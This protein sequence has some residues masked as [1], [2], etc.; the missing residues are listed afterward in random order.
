MNQE[1]ITTWFSQHVSLEGKP[2]TLDFDQAR[3]VL[4][5]HKNT[6]VTA[7]A[8]S[9]KTRVIVAKVAYL[10]AHEHY[11]PEEIAV[12]MFNRTAAAEVNQR[13]AA[14]KIDGRNL[15]DTH[16][17]NSE[18]FQHSRDPHSQQITTIASTFHKYALDLAKLAGLRPTLLSESEQEEHIRTCLHRALAQIKV[19]P[20]QRQEISQLTHNFIARAGQ[21]FPGLA[22]FQ[23]LAAAIEE[24]YA[25]AASDP[26]LRRWLTLHRVAH[27]TYYD[28]ITH[29]RSPHLD[30]NLLMARA[31]ELLMAAAENPTLDLEPIRQRVSPL[32]YIMVD[33]YQDFSYL[34][35]GIIRAMR[36]LCPKAKLF[37][38]GDDW[39]AINRFAGSNCDYFLRF[40]SYF[41]EDATN[42]PLAT[43]YRSCRRIV[44]NANEFMLKHYDP[45]ATKAIPKNHHSGK[46]YRLN[47]NKVRFD[48]S[49]VHEDALGDGAFQIILAD[50]INARLSATSEPVLPHKVPVE[51]A[52]LLKQVTQI[53]RKY[54]HKSIMLLHRYNFT[55]FDHISLE[56]FTQAL[57]K[58]LEK[59][60]IIS[61]E[62]YVTQVR[63]LTMHKSK[64]LEADVVI[65]LEANREQ[66]F[67][68]HPYAQ[69]FTIFGDTRA[70][71]IS[72]QQRLLYVAMTRAKEKLYILS[73]DPKCPI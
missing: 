63:A 17:R 45:N 6:L 9:G 8:G 55:S 40:S 68:S 70:A 27:Q 15:L 22:G 51:A 53:C 54:P 25:L 39:Q 36:T 46:I 62:N 59:Q 1:T 29:L 65:L 13:I 28:Y 34:F 64:G 67:S 56:T 7:R 16:L 20:K 47:P 44:E 33:E 43:N 31:T 60:A 72:D 4:D 73:T 37:A 35:F 48:S 2:Y 14:V 24:Y 11:R 5:S 71:E 30:F 23:D 66:I 3:A 18:N 50:C 19:S 32:R 49:D 58:V 42:I 61:S 57:R 38:V 41:P 69:V 10:I 21:N 26:E 12:F 52:K